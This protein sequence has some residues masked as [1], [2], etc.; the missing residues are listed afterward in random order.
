[1]RSTMPALLLACLLLSGCRT[2]ASTNPSPQ[3]ATACDQVGTID[4]LIS[5][6]RKVEPAAR[7]HDL[8]G[9]K[10]AADDARSQAAIILAWTKAAGLD[11]RVNRAIWSIGG[12]GDQGV[13]PFQWDYA[14]YPSNPKLFDEDADSYSANVLPLLDTD[15]LNVGTE[16]ASAGLN[17]WHI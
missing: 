11:E 17:C 10:S 14:L 4:A 12:L 7:A 5:D 16:F 3:D 6:L 8:A 2:S 1:M 13:L 9:L 15:T